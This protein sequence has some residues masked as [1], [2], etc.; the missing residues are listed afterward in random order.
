MTPKTCSFIFKQLLSFNTIRPSLEINLDLVR[1][2]TPGCTCLAFLWYSLVQVGYHLQCKFHFST[3]VVLATGIT[4]FTMSKTIFVCRKC[5][6]N[7]SYKFK[8]FILS[9]F[10]IFRL[11]LQPSSRIRILLSSRWK[12][13]VINDFILLAHAENTFQVI[14]Y[15]VH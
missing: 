7:V 11:M 6:L 8:V 12:Q 5:L 9:E 14:A 13:L 2:K 1:P 3:S 15:K 4:T 10:Y